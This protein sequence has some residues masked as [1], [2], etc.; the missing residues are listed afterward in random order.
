MDLSKP[1]PLGSGIYADTFLAG[2]TWR[3]AWAEISE[4]GSLAIRVSHAEVTPGRKRYVAERD[5]RFVFW[6]SPALNYFCPEPW[7]GE[8]NALNSGK[9][10]RNLGPGE[11]FAWEMRITIR[12]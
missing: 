8:P 3:T 5:I 10:L 11:R 2:Y 9:N 12:K 7:S 1:V 6:G 4:P